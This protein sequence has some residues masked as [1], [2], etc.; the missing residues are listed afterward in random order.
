MCK[1]VILSETGTMENCEDKDNLFFRKIFSAFKDNGSVLLIALMFIA[2][3]VIAL[4]TGNSVK[5]ITSNYSYDVLIILVVMELFTGL[6]TETGLM[7]LL[8]VKLA[9]ISQGRKKRCLVLFGVMMFLISC[10]LNNI[11]AVMM[12]LPVVFILLKT[13]ETDESYIGLFFATI[14]ALSN[15]GGAASPVGDFP[16]IVI[17]TSGITDFISYFTHAFPLFAVTS[18]ILVLVWAFKVH[19]ENDDSGIRRLAILNIKSQY[20][21]ITV[22]Y[23]VIKLLGVIFVAMFA[24]WSFIPQKIV[25]P[26]AIAMIGYVS[27]ALVCSVKK[28]KVPLGMN[29]KSLLTIAS[30]LFFAEAVSETGV[31][32]SIADC[33]QSHISDPKILI[34]AIMIITSIVA[35]VFSAGPAAAAMMPIIINICSTS[36]LSGKSDW[37]AVAY[38]ASICAGSS[39]FMWSATAGFILSGKVNDAE[40]KNDSGK[41]ATWGIGQYLKYGF[42]NYIIQ[43]SIAIIAMLVIL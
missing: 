37:I 42:V 24:S 7:Q 15:T 13:I 25:P 41:C 36:G 27:A 35:G 12:I 14:L 23:D 26:E 8:A 18:A 34:I 2:A 38:A 21:N 43:I 4:C 33:L 30:F 3:T 28:V 22:R 19:R 31:L 20:R 1:S 11:T 6:I 9:E 32:S 39:M 29:L 16:A 10:F 17:M 40:I 5:S